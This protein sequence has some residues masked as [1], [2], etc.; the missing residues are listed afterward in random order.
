MKKPFRDPT[1]GKKI[2]SAD[3]R[4]A[5]WDR[6]YCSHSFKGEIILAQIGH[7]RMNFNLDNQLRN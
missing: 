4:D 7:S 5:F 3:M 2:R 1:R 6:A